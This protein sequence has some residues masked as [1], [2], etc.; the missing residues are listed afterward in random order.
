MRKACY[1]GGGGLSN[2]LTAR[3]KKGEREWRKK[4][5]N[6]EERTDQHKSESETRPTCAAL[7]ACVVSVVSQ[8][9]AACSSCDTQG[10][11]PDLT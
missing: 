10:K 6:E 5:E 9:S 1:S 11:V 4:K 7:R 2:P 8:I 3:D